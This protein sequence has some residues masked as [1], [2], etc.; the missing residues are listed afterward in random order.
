MSTELVHSF[1]G[2]HPFRPQCLR[3]LLIDSEEEIDDNVGVEPDEYLVWLLNDI[4]ARRCPRCQRVLHEGEIASG[5]RVTTCRCIPICG[6]CGSDEVWDICHPADWRS[7]EPEDVEGRLAAITLRTESAT[8][9]IT[10]DPIITRDGVLGL[11]AVN[12]RQH[13]GGWAEFGYDDT[14]DVRESAGG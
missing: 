14:E 12:F 3:A 11:E 13:P 7:I 5:S 2:A 6:R 8:G 1:S 4:D 10:D 9:A